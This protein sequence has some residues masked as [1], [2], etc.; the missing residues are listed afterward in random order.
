VSRRRVEGGGRREREGGGRG[1]GE[2]GRSVLHEALAYK[3]KLDVNFLLGQGM[4]LNV[5]PR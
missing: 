1:E 2:G 4:P 3:H 5:V